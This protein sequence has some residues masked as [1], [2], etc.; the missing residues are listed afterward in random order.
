MYIILKDNKNTAEK[1][2]FN[3]IGE[4]LKNKVSPGQTNSTGM[5]FNK[6]FNDK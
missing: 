1:K 5:H 2:P 3:G 4:N 6:I